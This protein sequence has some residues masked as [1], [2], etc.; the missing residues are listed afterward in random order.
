MESIR[1]RVDGPFA[2]TRR[3]HIAALV[4]D[5]VDDL[6]AVAASFAGFGADLLAAEALA[7]A[8]RA[9]RRAGDPRRATRLIRAATEVAARCEGARTPALVLPDDELT[10]LSRRELEVA[11]LAA[12]GLSSDEIAGRL[13]LSVRTVDNHLQHVY[14]KLGISSRSELTRALGRRVVRA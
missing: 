6:E 13:F 3:E 11:D 10:P 9:A 5:D 7:A 12:S 2:A 1:D 8:A 14:Q 4:A